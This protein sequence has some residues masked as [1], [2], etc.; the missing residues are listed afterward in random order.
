MKIHCLFFLFFFSVLNIQSQNH[1]LWNNLLQKHVSVEGKVNYKAFLQDEAKLAKYL[2]ELSE[3]PPQESWSITKKKAYLIN[4][5]NAFTV[6]L[7][8]ENYPVN[9]IKDIGGLVASPFKKEF[10]PLGN[11]VYSLDAIEKEMLLKLG[12]ER[13]HFAINCA[14]YSC[15]KLHNEAFTETN[16]EAKL[17]KLSIAFVNDKKLNNLKADQVELSKIFKWYKSDFET[18]GQDLIDYLNKFSHIQ[19][20]AD[21]KIS[22]KDY[23]W[24]LNGK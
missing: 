20:K 8:L 18:D 3:N 13:V 23:N 22:F 10:I 4:V 1:Q 24:D 15:P 16:L 21:A 9:S 17:E 7:I 11:K 19:V 12:D 2:K 6:Q 14:S 5:Y